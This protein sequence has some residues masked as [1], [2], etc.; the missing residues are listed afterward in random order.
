MG[1]GQRPNSTWA[2][3]GAVDGSPFHTTRLPSLQT[4]YRTV[5]GVEE[6]T[7]VLEEVCS[8]VQQ[9][10][11]SAESIAAKLSP[12]SA[13]ELAR[14]LAADTGDAVAKPPSRK[15][16]MLLGLSSCV[17]FIGFGCVIPELLCVP[18]QLLPGA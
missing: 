2:S 6:T 12:R 11:P 7:A 17:P 18:C 16:L 10:A 3:D 5:V 8:Q 1:R 14:A 15:T 9:F 4:S 13:R